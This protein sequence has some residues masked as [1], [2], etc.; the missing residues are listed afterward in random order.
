M[1]FVKDLLVP[2]EE[3]GTIRPEM[4]LCEAIRTLKRTPNRQRAPA[5]V[6]K[7]EASLVLDT[8]RSVVG[9]LLS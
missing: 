8:G 5:E 7:Y 6:F 1:K 2:G 4:T 9:K 3:C